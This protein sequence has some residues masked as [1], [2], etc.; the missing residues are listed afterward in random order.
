MSGCSDRILSKEGVT[1]GDPLSMLLYAIRSC[2]T[3]DP[4]L[5]QFCWCEVK[6]QG[7]GNHCYSCLIMLGHKLLKGQSKGR[8]PVG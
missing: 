7:E 4:I 1:Q 3:T 5:R 2:A 6:V 8:I